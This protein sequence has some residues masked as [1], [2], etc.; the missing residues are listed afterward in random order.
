MELA[1]IIKWVDDTNNH[2]GDLT[3]SA[4]EYNEDK[5][6]MLEFKQYKYAITEQFLKM[7]NSNKVAFVHRLFRCSDEFM[8]CLRDIAKEHADECKEFSCE[9]VFYIE[10]E[11]FDNDI[12]AHDIADA[13]FIDLLKI[14]CE[15]ITL[16]KESNIDIG[17]LARP[18]DRDIINDLVAFLMDGERRE[19]DESDNGKFKR[20]PHIDR[21]VAVKLLLEKAGVKGIDRTRLASFVEAVTGGNPATAPKNSYAYRNYNTK[22]ESKAIELLRTIGIEVE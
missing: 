21:I 18:F 3:E 8:G 20:V 11:I 6:Y 16:C 9:W 4:R 19:A 10:N 1:Q 13:L 7:D 5:G 14:Y 2:F 22:N 17:A 12:T 15:V